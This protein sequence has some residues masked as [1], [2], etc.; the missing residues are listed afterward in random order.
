MPA[1]DS[2]TPTNHTKKTIR[3]NQHHQTEPPNRKA[4]I[5]KWARNSKGAENIYG[6]G[7]EK[8]SIPRN[9]GL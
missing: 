6:K 1:P 5:E 2:P 8:A 9:T 7:M 4:G 3:P